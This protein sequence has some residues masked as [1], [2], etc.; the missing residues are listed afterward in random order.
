MKARVRGFTLIELLVVIAIMGIMGTVSVNGYRAMQRGIEERGVMDNVNQFIRSA[1][2]RA[3]IDRQPVAIYFWNETISEETDFEPVHVSGRAVAVRRSGRFTAV[4]GNKLADEFGDL[5][6]NRLVVDGSD[7]GAD[8]SSAASSASSSAGIWIY[9][10]NGNEGT[11]PQRSLV[12][13]TTRRHKVDE[14]LPLADGGQRAPIISYAYEKLGGAGDATWNVG[15]AYGFEFADLELPRGYIFGTSFS[16]SITSPVA[17][18]DVIRFKVSVNL[19]NGANQ[20]AL[21]RSTVVV[22]SL[23]PDQGG[24]LSAQKVGTSADPTQRMQ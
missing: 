7:E 4:Q 16:R 21:G 14:L 12:G 17:G 15:D 9:K 23:R 1:Y 3:Q 20:G 24:S 8:D 13:Q 11:Q 19:G 6:Y 5:S 2:Q 22:S 18:E 10:M